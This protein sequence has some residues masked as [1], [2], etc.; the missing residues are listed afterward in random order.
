MEDHTD[1]I[2]AILGV[3]DPRNC[4]VPARGFGGGRKSCKEG[5]FGFVPALFPLGF[6]GPFFRFTFFHRERRLFCYKIFNARCI[7]IFINKLIKH[8][9]K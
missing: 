4:V 7:Y 5:G 8:I 3:S 6:S 1:A 2:P 9:T